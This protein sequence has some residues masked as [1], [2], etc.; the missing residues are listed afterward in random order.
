MIAMGEVKDMEYL[1]VEM[2]KE[3]ETKD[4]VLRNADLEKHWEFPE[5]TQLNTAR[6]I[7]YRQFW[8]I[9]PLESLNTTEPPWRPQIPKR[10]LPRLASFFPLLSS[11]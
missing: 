1:K 9:T 4:E 7:L 10:P 2:I 11:L 3:I 5:I 8:S 6:Y